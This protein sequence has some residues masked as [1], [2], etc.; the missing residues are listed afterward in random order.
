M[1]F[2]LQ[3][4]F[5]AEDNTTFL[6]DIFICFPIKGKEKKKE[7]LFFWLINAHECQMLI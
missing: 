5:E 6:V 3:G 2:K 7:Q 4:N 1:N